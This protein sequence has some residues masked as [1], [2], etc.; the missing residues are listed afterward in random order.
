MKLLSTDSDVHTH[1]LY[2]SLSSK[3]SISV[4]Q[5]ALILLILHLHPFVAVLL[6]KPSSCVEGG[7]SRSDLQRVHWKT[8]VLVSVCLWAEAED[9]AWP[10]LAV[11]GSQKSSKTTSTTTS[12]LTVT[13]GSSPTTRNICSKH[14]WTFKEPRNILIIWTSRALTWYLHVNVS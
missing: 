5:S 7:C 10:P 12:T 8:D 9:R 2:S 14:C 11:E 1:T 13:P 6:N 4:T 3:I